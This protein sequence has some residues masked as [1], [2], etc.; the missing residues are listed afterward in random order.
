M[1]GDQ[2]VI[3]TGIPLLT[4]DTPLLMAVL[5]RP[6]AERESAL[7][8][9]SSPSS[10]LSSGALH[11]G[12][13]CGLEAMGLWNV[14][15]RNGSAQDVLGNLLPGFVEPMAP[16]LR[17]LLQHRGFLRLHL[18]ARG[19]AREAPCLS[20]EALSSKASFVPAL[21]AQPTQNKGGAAP[22]A[23][24]WLVCLPSHQVGRKGPHP[25][26]KPQGNTGRPNAFCRMT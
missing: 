22:C 16:P 1:N 6:A 13:E 8:F 19:S 21:P 10:P 24:G 20:T 12:Q 25:N 15:G 9:S 11:K 5:G 23:E 2:N 4:G 17:A 14:A 7:L 3:P 18:L 26:S